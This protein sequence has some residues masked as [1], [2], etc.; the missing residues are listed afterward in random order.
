MKK[1]TIILTDEQ[2]R[3][4]V[5]NQTGSDSNTSDYISPL[6]PIFLTVELGLTGTNIAPPKIRKPR[7]SDPAFYNL[8]LGLAEGP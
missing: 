5:E 1:Y 2:K 3:V 7:Q 6:L 8:S 4:W